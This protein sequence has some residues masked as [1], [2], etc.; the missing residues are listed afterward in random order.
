MAAPGP[1]EIL[2]ALVQLEVRKPAR[3]HLQAQHRNLL[4]KLVVRRRVETVHGVQNTGN[5]RDAPRDTAH[6]C[7]LRV[8]QMHEIEA[9]ALED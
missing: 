6:H 8:V 2:L 4:A 1:I 5:A 9:F 7:W 3:E